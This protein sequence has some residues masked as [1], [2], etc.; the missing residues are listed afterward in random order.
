MKKLIIVPIISLCALSAKVMAQSESYTPWQ[1]NFT[2]GYAMASGDGVKGGIALYLE[3]KYHIND[4]IS[5]GLRAGVA[6]IAKS[7]SGDADSFKVAGIGSYLLTGNYY[8]LKN[9]GAFRPFGGVGVGYMKAAGFDTG[10]GGSV[11]I[12]SGIGGLVRVGFDVSHFTLDLEYNLNPSTKLPDDGGKISNSFL[13][14]NFGFYFGG[15]S[16][17]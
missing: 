17:K 12:T 6:L 11:G 9:G 8:F 15:G 2:G 5:V 1:L 16:K 13:G 3:P 14:V 7:L 10:L 4:N